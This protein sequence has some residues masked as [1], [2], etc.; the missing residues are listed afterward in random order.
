[1]Q[2]AE[3][4][5]EVKSLTLPHVL[6]NSVARFQNL[7]SKPYLQN[8]IPGNRSEHRWI[9]LAI[10]MFWAGPRRSIGFAGRHL[11]ALPEIF[12]IVH[13]GLATS[14]SEIVT[15]HHSFPFNSLLGQMPRHSTCNLSWETRQKKGGLFSFTSSHS[16]Q[17]LPISKCLHNTS[18]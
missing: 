6:P 14:A 13:I 18:L 3:V 10:P 2:N 7:N 11:R 8:N 16:S 9:C 1:M 15:K 5:V 12:V 4:A 17:A